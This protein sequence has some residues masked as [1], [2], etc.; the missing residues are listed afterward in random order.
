MG[1]P[2]ALL[3]MSDASNI[4]INNTY[5]SAVIEKV[6]DGINEEGEA[7]KKVTILTQAGKYVT[8]PL[9]TDIAP[10]S[11]KSVRSAAVPGGYRAL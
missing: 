9:D 3:L 10:D 11:F 6:V 7:C 8:Y 5:D 4:S 1:N 2:K